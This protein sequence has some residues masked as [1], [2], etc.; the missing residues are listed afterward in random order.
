MPHR[1]VAQSYLPVQELNS[2]IPP[3]ILA[4]SN[5]PSELLAASEPVLVVFRSEQFG[6][7]WPHR[8]AGHRVSP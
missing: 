7:E 3:P 6:V 1:L 4:L 2:V 8:I 5:F